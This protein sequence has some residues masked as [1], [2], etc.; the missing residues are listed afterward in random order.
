M[1]F[2]YISRRWPIQFTQFKNQALVGGNGSVGKESVRPRA[3][4]LRTHAE[5][6]WAW[7]TCSL[8]IQETET[9]D[10]WGKT[11]CQNGTLQVHCIREHTYKCE[12]LHMCPPHTNM[13]VCTLPTHHYN[14]VLPYSQ[15]IF[16]LSS[17]DDVSVSIAFIFYRALKVNI[18]NMV[19]SFLIFLLQFLNRL[20][21]SL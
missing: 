16:L 15:F 21:I 2:I 6:K 14:P 11:G 4:I 7:S 17:I 5:A 12:P 18:R 9:R 13:H 20:N 3:H 8:S 10:S 1:F 19:L